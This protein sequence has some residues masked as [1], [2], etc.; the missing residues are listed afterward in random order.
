MIFKQLNVGSCRTYLV[1]AEKSREALLIDPVLTYVEEYLQILD[2][3]K[4]HLSYIIDTHTHADHLSAGPA[5]CDHLQAEYVMHSSTLS[6]CPTRRVRGGEKIR[7]G[8]IAIICEHTPGHTSDSISLVLNDRILTGDFLFIGDSGSGRLDL[9]TGDAGEHFDSLQKLSQY[10]DNLMIF[11]AHDYHERTH[12]TLGKEKQTNPR[13]RFTS[14][15]E[16]V[17]FL[18][19]LASSTPEW[20]TQVIHANH[21]CSRD[22]K[23]VE[24]PE[25][26]P[27]CEVNG[28]PVTAAG[29]AATNFITAEQARERIHLGQSV[30][31]LDV[32]NP[33]EYVGQLGHIRGSRLIPVQELSSRISEIGEYRDRDVI[34]VCKSGGRSAAAVSILTQAGFNRAS[35][36]RGGMIQWNA[37]GYPVERNGA[38]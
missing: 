13:L 1:A 34:A 9:P 4:L 36:M 7:I 27:C 5:L 19:N 32:R 35:S 30:L 3:G 17:R 33:D 31:V 2:E 10:P 15:D 38:S 20:M 6:H 24:I 29:E 26:L 14:R 11:P 16:Y 18:S 12:S 22:P 21:T 23:A 8:D 25:D 37:N 28:T